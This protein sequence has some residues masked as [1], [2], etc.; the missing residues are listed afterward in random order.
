MMSN[1]AR[2]R[3]TG[4]AWRKPNLRE[5]F[6]TSACAAAS[7]AAAARALLTGQ[8]VSEITID[9]PAKE[10]VVFPVARCEM[11]TGHVTCGVIKDAGDDPD[12]THGAEIQATVEWQSVPGVQIAGGWGVGIVTRPGLPVPVGEP[13]INPGSRRIIVRAVRQEARA[14]LDERGLKVTISV[15]N[16]DALAQRTLNPRLG[17]VGGISILGTTG[18]VK[19]F[20]LAAYRASIQLE[21]RV[22]VRNGVRR[23]VLTTGNRSEQY[24][25]A[26]RPAGPELGFVQVGD[27]MGYALRQARRLGMEWVIIAGML[28][29]ISKLAQGRMQ[30]HVSKGGVDLEFLGRVAGQLGADRALIQRVQRANTAR[31]VQMMLRRA[32]ILGLEEYLA[33]QAAEQAFALV[34]GAFPIDV[35]LFDIGGELLA[36][37]RAGVSARQQHGQKTEA[38]PTLPGL[39]GRPTT[40]G[41]AGKER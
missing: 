38:D 29:K 8:V 35:W 3:H 14:V 23:A 27:Q 33:Q 2:K 32:G 9:L 7:A 31:H 20:S 5:G 30:T 39:G 15:P 17:I 36:K 12:V 24:A 26:R 4:R 40:S 34:E 41:K 19:P 18:I 1:R 13:A 6:T 21:L 16:G 37:G 28:G 25:L 22:A 11:G 10:Q